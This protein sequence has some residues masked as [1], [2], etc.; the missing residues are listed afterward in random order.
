MLRIS[1][2]KEPV[3]FRRKAHGTKSGY[4][5]DPFFVAYELIPRRTLLAEPEYPS[6]KARR[7]SQSVRQNLHHSYQTLRTY[8]YFRGFS[9]SCGPPGPFEGVRGEG[10]FGFTPLD[11]SSGCFCLGFA[12]AVSAV[13]WGSLTDD[14]FAGKRDCCW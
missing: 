11:L 12:D 5:L 13:W 3:N 2:D 6:A 14:A 9:N 4:L 8:V 1:L 7:S 10:V